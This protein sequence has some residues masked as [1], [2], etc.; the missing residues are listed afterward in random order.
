MGGRGGE[1]GYGMGGNTGEA[2]TPEQE[3]NMKSVVLQGTV[4][5]FNPPSEAGAAAG[6]GTAAPQ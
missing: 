3:P 1:G 2:M 4:Y 5:I 6:E